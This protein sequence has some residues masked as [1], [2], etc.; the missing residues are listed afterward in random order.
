MK[1]KII[2]IILSVFVFG[3]GVLVAKSY[4]EYNNKIG[5][6][7]DF[8]ERFVTISDFKKDEKDG[9][10]FYDNE[11]AKV[12]FKLPDYWELIEEDFGFVSLKTKD[13]IPY[14]NDW[15][16]KPLASEGCWVEVNIRIDKLVDGYENMLD[17]YVENDEYINNDEDETEQ[18]IDLG[19]SKAIKTLSESKK[20]GGK[21]VFIQIPNHNITYGFSSYLFGKDQERCE[22]DFDDFLASL[23]IKNINE[24]Q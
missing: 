1:K 20:L 4:I 5:K 3:L 13:F 7:D 17:E 11:K 21:T 23:V 24:N 6:D 19:Y 15:R 2:I 14:D 9:F 22:K 16:K 10:V 8:R 12:I 18:V